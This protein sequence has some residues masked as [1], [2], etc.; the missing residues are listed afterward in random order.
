MFGIGKGWKGAAKWD[1]ILG[2]YG[3]AVGESLDGVVAGM[4]L[5][6]V[7]ECSVSSA[8]L[9]I[10]VSIKRSTLFLFLSFARKL[11]SLRGE[12]FALFVVVSVVLVALLIK[13]WH[14]VL[15]S[16]GKIARSSLDLDLSSSSF[17]ISQSIVL[18]L[19]FVRTKFECSISSIDFER[20]SLS[21][22][23]S[24]VIGC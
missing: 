16:G 9:I 13:N 24:Q 23:K 18:L 15:L 11:I 5:S 17:M 10:L 2:E 19:V 1:K 21:C 7:L 4:L 12:L 3:C 20:S 6:T 14:V 8:R 22:S